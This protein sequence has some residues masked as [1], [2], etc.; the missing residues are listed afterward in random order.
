MKAALLASVAIALALVSPASATVVLNFGQVSGVN[1][2][3]AT[4]NGT[5]TATTIN[6]TNVAINITQD[7]GGF[8]G[9]AILNL[10]A[11]STDAAVLVGTSVLQHFNG[12][13]HITSGL[14]GTGTNFLS[15]TFT[16]AVFGTGPSLTLSVGAPPD[17]ITTTSDQIPAIDLG[18]PEAISLSFSNVLPPV[19]IAGSTLAGFTSSIAGNFSATPVFEPSSLAIVGLG[20]V[21]LGVARR[22]RR[23]TLYGV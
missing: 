4:P 12:S 20:L 21:G 10:N 1:T 19:G 8:L 14:G 5:D 9:P 15:G 2:I 7:I 17:T 13:W 18:L 11:A 6:G 3:T 16:D 23:P 22:R